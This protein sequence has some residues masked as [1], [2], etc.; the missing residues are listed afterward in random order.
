MII[1]TGE[2]FMK[3]SYSG[4]ENIMW[5]K[6]IRITTTITYLG[7]NKVLREMGAEGNEMSEINF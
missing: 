5:N 3:E 4:T 2:P 6:L 1:A 7:E